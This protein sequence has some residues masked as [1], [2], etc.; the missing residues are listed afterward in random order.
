[1]RVTV[2]F[3]GVR[4]TTED[5]LNAM[6]CSTGGLM[7]RAVVCASLPRVAVIVGFVTT[8]TTFVFTANVADVWP[9]AIVTLA[10]T[11]AAAELLVS[12][13]TNPPTVAGPVRVTVPVAEEPPV[14][15]PGF[16]LT[17]RRVGG[18]TVRVA[19]WVAP[20]NVALIVA[21]FW[22]VSAVVGMENVPLF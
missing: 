14:R 6:D 3:P 2:P 11:V 20:A 21:V 17:D 12:F 10:G 9:A 5:G 22:A 8:A 15:V 13:T 19:D 4:P 16:R 18:T 7:V 1:M